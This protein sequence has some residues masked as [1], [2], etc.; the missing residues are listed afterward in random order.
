MWTCLPTCKLWCQRLPDYL[1]AIFMNVLFQDHILIS[2][3]S[4]LSMNSYDNPSSRPIWNH[5]DFLKSK[6][7]TS[8]IWCSYKKINFRGACRIDLSC[9]KSTNSLVFFG[10]LHMI[11]AHQCMFKASLIIPHCIDKVLCCH[12][13]L[14]FG[15]YC[16]W[17]TWN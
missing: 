2:H 17:K 4:F 12:S 10:S 3:I 7:K 14:I 11:V 9:V 15:N 8:S 16:G 6:W 5:Y 13:P 1:W